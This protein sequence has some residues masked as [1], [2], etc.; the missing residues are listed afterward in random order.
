MYKV[1][2]GIGSNLGDREGNCVRAVELVDGTRG[3]RIIK[4]SALY[5]TEPVGVEGHDWYVNGAVSLASE[6]SAHELLARLLEIESKMGRVRKGTW[7]PRPID[8]DIL[9][10]GR[11][12]ITEDGLTVPHPRMHLRRF[13]LAPMAQLEPDLVHP[14]L[15]LTM[16]ELLEGLPEEGQRVIMIGKG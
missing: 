6:I 10:F 13:V 5:R 1:Y 7:D 16:R 9:L 4:M 8:L 14:V 12:I 2:I 15:G 3:C 11:D